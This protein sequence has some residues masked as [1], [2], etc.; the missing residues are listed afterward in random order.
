MPLIVN[1]TLLS[2]YEMEKYCTE[3]KKNCT[4][5]KK[6]ES[7][8]RG[9]NIALTKGKR[10]M[11]K[12]ER[13][14]KKLHWPGIEPGPPAWQARILPLNHQCY[15]EMFIYSEHYMMD[16]LVYDVAV[17]RVQSLTFLRT[18]TFGRCIH[19]TE[20][21]KKHKVPRTLDCTLVSMDGKP[22]CY[23]E[24]YIAPSILL[25]TAATWSIKLDPLSPYSRRVRDGLAW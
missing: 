11:Q 23:P 16:N 15:A 3:E 10:I 14:K 18:R 4:D 9:Y 13:K 24:L 25:C 12:V 6:Q 5:W 1:I 2:N 21:G 8:K 19:L 22:V 20:L 17:V 7:W